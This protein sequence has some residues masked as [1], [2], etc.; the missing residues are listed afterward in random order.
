MT[1]YDLCSACTCFT[2]CQMHFSLGSFHP[3]DSPSIAVGTLTIVVDVG[4]PTVGLAE[5]AMRAVSYGIYAEAGLHSKALSKEHTLRSAS[6]AT[7]SR[8]MNKE[9]NLPTLSSSS[10][11]EF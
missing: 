5:M 6:M 3:L 1:S 7:D 11:P 4:K 9:Q 8:F 10:R 2:S